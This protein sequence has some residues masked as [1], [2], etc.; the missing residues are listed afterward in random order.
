MNRIGYL[1]EQFSP[2]H[3]ED[4]DYCY[5]ARLAGYQMKIAG[6]VRVHHHCS[7]SFQKQSSEQIYNLINTNHHKFIEKWGIDSHQF[8]E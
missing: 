1:D 4:D 7:M 2:G 5:R 8:I 6:D 3:Y